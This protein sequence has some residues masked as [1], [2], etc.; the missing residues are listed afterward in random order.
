[1]A[2]S[3]SRHVV[4]CTLP[5]YGHVTPL[6]D[7]VA[8][9]RARGHRVTVATGAEFTARLAAAGAATVAYGP[10]DSGD[11]GSHATARAVS[12]FTGFLTALAPVRELLA[13]DPPDLLGFDSTMWVAGRVLAA[14]HSCPVVQLSPCFVSNEHF[15][16]AARVAERVRG[17]GEDAC[18]DASEDTGGPGG[19]GGA[20]ALRSALA[21]AG[22]RGDP[23]DL[24]SDAGDHKLV[25]MP[26][27]FQYRGDTFDQRHT[28]VG[29]CLGPVRTRGDWAPPGNGDPVLLISLGTSLFN[30]QPDF[31]R[32]C[33]AAFA[34]LPWNV[35]M[36]LGNGTDP[37]QLGPLPA[38]VRAH[39]WLPHPLV[40]AAARAS[41][42]PA[43]MGSIM[44]S[45]A[46]DTPLVVVPQHGEQAVNADRV[47]ELGLG[48]RLGR[49]EIR[50]E[51]VRDS[52]LKVA[53][54]P[55]IADRVHG[56]SRS[57]HRAGGYRRA[58]DTL[59]ALAAAAG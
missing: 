34:D 43:G 33:A 59:L 29:P 41:V 9:L 16:L 58:A 23:A 53:A 37:A 12:G 5:G 38:N 56:M 15:S 27:E 47:A 42:C 7:I 22:L 49:G 52:V 11:S 36:T 32:S 3:P 30:D 40:L 10:T 20:G 57:C 14:A 26:K 4:L 18:Q 35:V 24:L 46:C 48:T 2:S 54:D 25:F 1:M 6:L 45:L 44:E 17:T 28:F 55:D 19:D 13:T 39:R 50:A 21:A 8:E 31:F 51:A